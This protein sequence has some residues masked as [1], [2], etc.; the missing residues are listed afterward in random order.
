MLDYY[1]SL[2]PEHVIGVFATYKIKTDADEKKK[3]EDEMKLAKDSKE[4]PLSK[5]PKTGYG[6]GT[7]F[8]DEGII[9]YFA[10]KTGGINH[11][12][13]KQETPKDDDGGKG[14]S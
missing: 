6:D 3:I 9:K 4:I 12:F 7:K 13:S 11:N 8:T 1:F 14:K 10:E 5:D 2:S